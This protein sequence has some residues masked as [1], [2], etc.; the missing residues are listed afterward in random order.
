MKQLTFIKKKKVKKE[1][2]NK[3][4][5]T[6]SLNFI[7]SPEQAPHVEIIQF[8]GEKMGCDSNVLIVYIWS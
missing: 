7:F 6:K 1:K 4:K 5:I 3:G 8:Q 2:A